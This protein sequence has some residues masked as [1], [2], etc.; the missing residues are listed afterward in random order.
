MSNVIGINDAPRTFA[1][2]L[3]LTSADYE[4]LAAYA[5]VK[6]C[7]LDQA[8][9]RMIAG[10]LN[11]EPIHWFTIRHLL[12][13]AHEKFGKQYAPKKTRSLGKQR[14]VTDE[15]LEDLSKER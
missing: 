11:E 2:T 15:R 6:G 4:W 9:T 7:S 8:A 5:Q 3:T 12:N 1:V 10:S 13:R 14:A